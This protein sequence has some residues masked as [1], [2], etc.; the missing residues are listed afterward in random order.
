MMRRNAI[1]DNT[2]GFG[3]G[4]N[5]D[6]TENSSTTTTNLGPPHHRRAETTQ[7]AP[8]SPATTSAQPENVAV[9]GGWKSRLAWNPENLIQYLMVVVLIVATV[10]LCATS[11]AFRS[12]SNLLNV[13]SSSAVIGIVALGMLLTIITAGFDL[14]VG[15]VG[16]ASGCIAGAMSIGNG[17]ATAIVVALGVSLLVG[18]ASGFLIGVVGINPFITTFSVGSVVTGA[19]FIATDAIPIYGLPEAWINLGFAKVLGIPMPVV[20]WLI[21]MVSIWW[22]LRRTRFGLYVYAVGSSPVAVARAGISVKWM[23]VAVY[24]ICGLCAGLG[25]VLSVGLSRTGT[26]SAGAT[27]ALTAIAAVVLG[28]TSLRGG[29]GFV[30]S[31]I[32]G[33]L[34]L[35]VMTNAFTIFGLSPYFVPAV[36]GAV[37]LLAVGFESYTRKQAA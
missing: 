23:L 9:R 36:T 2:I 35:G 32:V 26:P 7:E 5:S 15:A 17:L 10:V 18:M 3:F 20:I 11:P 37:I 34:L 14:S 12:T 28:G 4:V 22:I 25:G 6:M 24:G 33:T 8:D 13:L 29:A 31:A 30:R 19:L 1:V 16:A 27:W 21:A